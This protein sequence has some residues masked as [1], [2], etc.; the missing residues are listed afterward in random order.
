[1]S[2]KTFLTIFLL[3]LPSLAFSKIRIMPLGNSITM[4]RHGEPGGYRD[5]LSH[6]LLDEGID[7]D[8]HDEADA[9]QD[10]G[11]G[12]VEDESEV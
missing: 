4:G 11:Y 2:N 1:M 5:D 8:E 7:E 10:V 9:N 6:M 12:Q 3:I